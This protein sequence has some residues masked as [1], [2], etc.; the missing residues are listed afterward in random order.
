MTY[1]VNAV[2]KPHQTVAKYVYDVFNSKEVKGLE[3]FT[4]EYDYEHN[5]IKVWDCYGAD[6]LCLEFREDVDAITIL[7]SR[8]QIKTTIEYF[9]KG[10]AEYNG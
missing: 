10:D 9:Q 5:T 2:N 6:D 7:N 1:P 3:W 8:S 4:I